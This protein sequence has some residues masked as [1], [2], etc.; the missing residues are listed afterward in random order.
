MAVS[1]TKRC[2][3]CF[4]K[5]INHYL[6]YIVFQSPNGVQNAFEIGISSAAKEGFNHQTVYRML[7]GNY[8]A[9]D[10]IGLSFNHQTVYRMLLI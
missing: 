7:Y 10:R 6:R 9:T 4:K 5:L 3:E 1:I 2:T 8:Y